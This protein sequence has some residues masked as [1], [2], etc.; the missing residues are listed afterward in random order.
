MPPWRCC[1]RRPRGV[2]LARPVLRDRRRLA[3]VAAV[4]ELKA[5]CH[6]VS[7]TASTSDVGV[8]GALGHRLNVAMVDR[9]GDASSC[10]R[11][12]RAARSDTAELHRA[13]P[14]VACLHEPFSASRP[15][16]S[17]DGATSTSGARTSA[18]CG[19]RRSRL[20]VI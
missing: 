12:P 10:S 19:A 13:R 1:A 3:R 7:R 17:D 15:L 8:T 18:T 20:V 14:T 11:G 16:P 9:T 4:G 5:A 6:V 2:Q